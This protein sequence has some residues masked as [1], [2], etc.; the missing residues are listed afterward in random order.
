MHK[1]ERV[2]GKEV[3]DCGTGGMGRPVESEPNCPGCNHGDDNEQL[4]SFHCHKLRVVPYRCES[5]GRRKVEASPTWMELSVRR[6]QALL[7]HVR[8][9]LCR[10]NVRMPE[11]FLN[12]PQVCSVAK[13]VDQQ[14]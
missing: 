14:R 13:E 4:K 3:C 10:R 6:L 5:V 7:I 9:N 2:F 8:V 12:D 11:H 1:C